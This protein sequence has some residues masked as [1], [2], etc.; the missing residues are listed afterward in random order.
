[1]PETNQSDPIRQFGYH[2]CAVAAIAVLALTLDATRP[3]DWGPLMLLALTA[4]TRYIERLVKDDAWEISPIV[5]DAALGLT[6]ADILAFW[7]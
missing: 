4:W 2:V 1:M 7:T 3:N 5:L 6:A